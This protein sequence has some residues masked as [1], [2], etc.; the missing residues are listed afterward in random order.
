MPFTNPDTQA[1]GGR[2]SMAK[3]TPAQRK[4]KARRAIKA[5]W[6]RVKRLKKA[7]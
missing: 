6:D 1:M 5:R 4:A 2:A 3:L 7:A